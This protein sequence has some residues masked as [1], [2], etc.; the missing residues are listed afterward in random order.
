MDSLPG[1]TQIQNLIPTTFFHT[2]G[3]AAPWLGLIGAAFIFVSGVSYLTWR[4][5]QAAAAGEGYGEGHSN[6]PERT[7]DEGRLA[8]PVVAILPLVI[9]GV[10]N[11]V[12][13]FYMP[14]LYGDK[15]ETVL[16][17][18][19]HPIVTTIS[20]VSAIWGARIGTADRHPEC[21]GFGLSPG[22]GTF[23]RGYQGK[24]LAAP[25]WPR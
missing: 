22:R 10:M 11:W 4:V 9:V 7:G 21:R 8:N 12:F 19:D 18:L 25:C 13:T 1:T 24:P 2:N 5:R 6:E 16:A 23:R 14:A 17:G 3:Y 20:S 15:N